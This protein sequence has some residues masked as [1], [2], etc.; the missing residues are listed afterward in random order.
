MRVYLLM[1]YYDNQQTAD[2]NISG[3]KVLGAFSS[4]DKANQAAKDFRPRLLSVEDEQERIVTELHPKV[5]MNA[6]AVRNVREYYD[7]DHQ[8]EHELYIRE[9]EV[10]APRADE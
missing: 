3:D 5:H 8:Y 10:D 1:D 9:E 2:R 4:Y 6:G 7:E